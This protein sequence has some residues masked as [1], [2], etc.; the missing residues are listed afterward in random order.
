VKIRRRACR[1]ASAIPTTPNSRRRDFFSFPQWTIRIEVEFSS[2]RAK[3]LSSETVY[4]ALPRSEFLAIERVAA[5]RLFQRQQA[6][7]D[8]GHNFCLAPNDPALGVRR[9]QI[10]DGQATPVGARLHVSSASSIPQ[11]RYAIVLQLIRSRLNHPSRTLGDSR[12]N[13]A[14]RDYVELTLFRS[15]VIG[16]IKRT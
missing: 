6:T 2:S 13:G 8:C 7:T 9:W 11:D 5:A 15:A 3:P 12:P 1:S 10:G 14:V 16:T 4:A